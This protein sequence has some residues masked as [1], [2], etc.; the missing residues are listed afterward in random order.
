[1]HIAERFKEYKALFIWKFTNLENLLRPEFFKEIFPKDGA[2]SQQRKWQRKLLRA[3]MLYIFQK[4][5]HTTDNL[6]L[7]SQRQS[8][9]GFHFLQLPFFISV[10]GANTPPVLFGS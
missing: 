4:N 10:P 1:M 3:E 5:A 6:L 2:T 8:L 7:T 9:K